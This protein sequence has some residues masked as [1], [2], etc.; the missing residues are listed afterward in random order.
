MNIRHNDHPSIN[1]T[2]VATVAQNFDATK[3]HKH[4]L[5]VPEQIDTSGKFLGRIESIIVRC[6]G[7]GGSN[8]SLTVK[9]TWDAAG[10]HVWFPDTAGTIALGVTTT[11]TGSAAYEFKLPVQSYFDNADV[12]L[13]FKI[14]GSGNITIDYSQIV[15]SE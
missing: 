9:G 4:T 8:T 12:Y 10:D 15:W 11:T 6:T 3:F 5:V 7:L 1:D 2:N 14:N 13:F